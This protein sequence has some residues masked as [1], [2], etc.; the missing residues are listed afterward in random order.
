VLVRDSVEGKKL[1]PE[2]PAVAKRSFRRSRRSSDRQIHRA[3][4]QP[5]ARLT[6]EGRIA[7]WAATIISRRAYEEAKT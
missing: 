3:L 6:L 5:H 2:V 1:P 7:A 4:H